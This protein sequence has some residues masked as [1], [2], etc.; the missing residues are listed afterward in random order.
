MVCQDAQRR[1]SNYLIA[2]LRSQLGVLFAELSNIGARPVMSID[3]VHAFVWTEQQALASSFWQ[4]PLVIQDFR[5]EAPHYSVLWPPSWM[6][7]KV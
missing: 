2:D 1:F 4:T 6:I 3:P 5:S 7:T